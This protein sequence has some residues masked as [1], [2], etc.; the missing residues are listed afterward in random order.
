MPAAKEQ[1]GVQTGDVAAV[2]SPGVDADAAPAVR[3]AS[4]GLSEGTREELERTGH[5]VDPFTGKTLTR[6]DLPK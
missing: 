2:T 6:D 5:A 3:E 1:K 4:F